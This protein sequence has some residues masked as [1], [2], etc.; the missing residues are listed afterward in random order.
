MEPNHSLAASST[1][2]L[3]GVNLRAQG[4]K[5]ASIPNHAMPATLLSGPAIVAAL[6]LTDK[7]INLRD[8][9][10]ELVATFQP[11]D[12]IA[13]YIEAGYEVHGTARRVRYLR[14]G[15]PK[16]KIRPSLPF[17]PCWLNQDA[18]VIRFHGEAA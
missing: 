7:P 14:P 12:D 17:V 3:K 9:A 10:G 8:A 6:L 18:A 11:G 13:S 16:A 5:G 2:Y 4:A 1:P 15:G